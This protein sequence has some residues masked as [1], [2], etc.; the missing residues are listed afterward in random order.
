MNPNNKNGQETVNEF[1]NTLPKEDKTPDANIFGAPKE[2][3]KEEVV[4]SKDDDEDVEDSVKN[5]RHRRLEDKLQA[6]REAN[7]ALSERVKV[8][9]EVDKFSKE[10]PEVDPDI[11]KM[12]DASDIGKEN[13]L[14][15]SR[16]LS[17]IQTKAE[18]RALE[19]IE[20]L[21]EKEAEEV[22]EAGDFI[23]TQLNNIE[24]QFGV[25][26]YGSKKAD[27]LRSEFLQFVEDIS[28][29]DKSG[30]IKDYADMETAFETFSALHTKEKPDN[31]RA[32]EVASR[33]MQRS[34]SGSSAPKVRTS[35]WDGWKTDMGLE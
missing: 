16:K 29:K 31:S 5:R 25:A 28:P 11:A 32:R 14:R 9:S 19:R 23:D 12:F 17:E 33:S 26:F 13:A 34:Q 27:T 6:E 3:P 7:I 1:F 2:T 20:E 15:L 22:K 10:N 4:V 30:E 8:L 21:K 18:E 35:G 24:D